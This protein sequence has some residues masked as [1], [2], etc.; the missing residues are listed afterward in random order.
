MATLGADFVAAKLPDEKKAKLK[1]IMD[2][3][4][5]DATAKTICE[6]LHKNLLSIEK[7]WNLT[8]RL[9]LSFSMPILN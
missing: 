6:T 7:Y 9:S 1:E 5:S 2:Y 8:V 3:L 4:K